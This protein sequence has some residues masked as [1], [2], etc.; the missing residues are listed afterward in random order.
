ML[1]CYCVSVFGHLVGI[2][3]LIV[4]VEHSGLLGLDLVEVSHADVS[5]TGEK[6]VHWRLSGQ[7]T[8]IDPG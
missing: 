1:L 7:G 5:E 2:L 3:G 4:E 6:W 8:V